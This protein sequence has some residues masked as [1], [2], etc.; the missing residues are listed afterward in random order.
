MSNWPNN[1]DLSSS[2]WTGRTPRESRNN[3]HYS[4]ADLRIPASGWVLMFLVLFAIFGFLPVL[5]MILGA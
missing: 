1:T 2:N 5:K 3:T 4:E